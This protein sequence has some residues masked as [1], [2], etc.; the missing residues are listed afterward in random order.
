VELRDWQRLGT[1]AGSPVARAWRRL[2]RQ[3][4]HALARARQR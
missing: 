1:P 3:V 2:K 4:L